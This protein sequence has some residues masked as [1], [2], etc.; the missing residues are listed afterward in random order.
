MQVPRLFQQ[1]TPLHP[2]EW[3]SDD[4]GEKCHV[5]SADGRNIPFSLSVIPLIGSGYLD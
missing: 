5:P 3:Q 1:T 2:A 4:A